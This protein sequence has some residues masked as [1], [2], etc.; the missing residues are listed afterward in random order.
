MDPKLATV[1]FNRVRV[2]KISIRTDHRKFEDRVIDQLMN[3]P[4]YSPTL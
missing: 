1:T 2:R 3:D 4:P